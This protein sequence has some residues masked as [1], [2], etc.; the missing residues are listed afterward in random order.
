MLISYS[1]PPD[2]SSAALST[3]YSHSVVTAALS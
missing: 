3:G 1:V 2:P